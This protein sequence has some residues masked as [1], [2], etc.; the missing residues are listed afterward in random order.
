MPLS[1][2]ETHEGLICRDCALFV[3]N[4]D[5]SGFSGDLDDYLQRVHDRHFGVET[6][7]VGEDYGFSSY[8]CDL[9]SEALAGDRV[10][11]TF[12]LRREN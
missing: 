8:D 2:L 3:A 6:V 9:C 11:A 1:E 4:G 7:A 5:T 12:F 10:R